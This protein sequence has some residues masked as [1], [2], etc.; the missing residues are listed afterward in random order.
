MFPWCRTVNVYNVEN[1]Y[2]FYAD[3][4]AI[5][6]PS[7]N[8]VFTKL[9]AAPISVTRANSLARN[10]KS[11]TKKGLNLYKNLDSILNP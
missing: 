10:S 1:H 3:N 5:R 7:H 8:A 2:H 9:K 4:C 6:H 11:K